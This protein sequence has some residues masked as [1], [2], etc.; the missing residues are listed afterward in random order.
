MR[1]LRSFLMAY[2][3]KV[4]HVFNEMVT[5]AQGGGG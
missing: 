4:I 1:K 2:A 5:F 3:D